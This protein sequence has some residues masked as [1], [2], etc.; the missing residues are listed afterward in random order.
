[1]PKS[2]SRPRAWLARLPRFFIHLSR[3]RCVRSVV[4]QT[5]AFGT[6]QRLPDTD[7]CNGCDRQRLAH[8][9]PCGERPRHY[10]A[11]RGS[12]AD[13]IPNNTAGLRL[14]FKVTAGL[15]VLILR[16]LDRQEINKFNRSHGGNSGDRAYPDPLKRCGNLPPVHLQLHRAQCPYFVSAPAGY[17]P[18]NRGDRPGARSRFISLNPADRFRIFEW[19]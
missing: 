19:R 3:N 10:T 2:L 12:D 13:G 17:K 9:L 8:V 6:H 18:M 14:N 1:M 7:Q 15:R 5:D 16:T 11:K 4:K